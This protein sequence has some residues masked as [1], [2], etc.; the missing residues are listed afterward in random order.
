MATKAAVE[1]DAGLKPAF[2]P[3]PC[4]GQCVA[5]AAECTAGRPAYTSLLRP[6]PSPAARMARSLRAA[7]WPSASQQPSPGTAAQSD[8]AYANALA[9]VRQRAAELVATV[10][11]S[12][13]KQQKAPG[14]DPA[15]AP[16]P[17][18][19]S[20]V[21]AGPNDRAGSAM[22]SRDAATPAKG[23]VSPAESSASVGCDPAFWGSA[24]VE[25]EGPLT[26]HMRD[27]PALSHMLAG[28]AVR[29]VGGIVVADPAGGDQPSQSFSFGRAGGVS[30]PDD[31]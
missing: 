19:S 1:V 7:L 16:Q 11:G 3:T 9:R 14:P 2:M 17:A 28:G 30:R 22:R 12:P 24:E 4:D 5:N 18:L 8:A 23:A 20:F 27:S 6:R 15:P 26:L 31:C 25:V 10:S 29:G 21:V 13:R